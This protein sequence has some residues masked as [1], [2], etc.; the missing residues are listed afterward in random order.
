[1]KDIKGIVAKNMTELRQANNMTQ[2]ELSEKLNYSDKT[3]S[4][5]ERA[6]STPDISVLAEM[7]ELFGVTLDYFIKE[8]HTEADPAEKKEEQAKPR[9]VESKYNRRIIAYIAE[10]IVWLIAIFAFIITSLIVGRLSFQY[11]YFIYALPVAMIVKLVFNSVWFNPRHN[12]YIISILIWSILAAI[13]I[14]FLY[15]GINVALV[16][17]LG[18]AIEIVIV[19]WSFLKKPPK[20]QKQENAN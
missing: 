16:Y 17:L 2:L 7:A 11:L 14:T 5:W 13:H 10:S 8:E 20:K 4:K 3:I 18:V 15:F 19:L 12:Y 1:M 6:E 9:A